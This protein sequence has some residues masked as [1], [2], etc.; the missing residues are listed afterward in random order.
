MGNQVKD[1]IRMNEGGA[2]LLS[3]EHC[4]RWGLAAGSEVVVRETSQ[5]LLLLPSG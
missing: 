4:R 3:N 2:L 1:T 5:G